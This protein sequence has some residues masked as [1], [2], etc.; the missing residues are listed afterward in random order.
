MRA[1]Y[2]GGP[3]PDNHKGARTAGWG[4]G[5]MVGRCESGKGKRVALPKGRLALEPTP[6]IVHLP[7]NGV[8]RTPSRWLAAT[9]LVGLNAV[10]GENP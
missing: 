4:A 10:S 6:R 7:R 8:G 9:G 3:A 5:S 1:N 2:R